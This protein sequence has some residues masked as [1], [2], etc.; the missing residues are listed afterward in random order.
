MRP[1][2]DEEALLDQIMGVMEAAFPPT[3]GERWTRAQ[4]SGTIF[5]P[6]YSWGLAW[7]HGEPRTPNEQA[8]G[9]YMSRFTYDE[10][11]LLLIGVQPIYRRHGLATRLLD[12]LEHNARERGAKRLLLEMRAGNPAELLYRQRGFQQIGTRKKYYCSADGKRIDALT[13]ACKI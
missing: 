7:R 5:L 1:E 11:E 8:A 2:F 13:F 9:F 12:D 10:E 6:N 3:F 4:V